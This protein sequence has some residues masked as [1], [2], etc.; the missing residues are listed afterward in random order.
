VDSSY[1]NYL[2]QFETNF[3]GVVK[4]TKAVLPHFREKRS[5]TVV[6]IGSSGGI[7]G[8]PGAGPVSWRI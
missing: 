7:A 6:F 5:G 1:E 3:F 2:A 8:E 4:V